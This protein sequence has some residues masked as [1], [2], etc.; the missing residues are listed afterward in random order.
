L[1]KIDSYL[2][3][4]AARMELGDG[5]KVEMHESPECEERDRLRSEATLLL[6]QWPA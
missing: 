3:D 4:E 5:R 6:G 2:A 1:E